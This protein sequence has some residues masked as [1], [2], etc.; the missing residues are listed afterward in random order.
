MLVERSNF[1]GTEQTTD[2]ST[3]PQGAEI[4][5][6][7]QLQSRRLLW[8]RSTSI[9]SCGYEHGF[10][11]ALRSDVDT[12][13]KQ[14]G[15]T[16]H[17]R[18]R[19]QQLELIRVGRLGDVKLL[20]VG[21]GQW[22]QDDRVDERKDRAARAESKRQRED[23]DGG[24]TRCSGEEAGSIAQ[25]AQEVFDGPECARIPAGLLHTIHAPHESAS[26]PPCIRR[27]ITARCGEFFHLF[28]VK[29]EFL[30]EFLVD[31]AA[32][33]ERANRHEHSSMETYGHSVQTV[34]SRTVTAEDRRRH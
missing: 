12:T 28:K 16:G 21:D 29:L 30:V 7:D 31:G 13:G 2:L 10:G 15:G 5:A 19:E 22:T 8:T 4:V 32:A 23:R 9:C 14:R 33:Q 24:E 34:S 18:I 1:T 3:L 25:I 26:A 11:A 6:C 20:R 17:H 27:A